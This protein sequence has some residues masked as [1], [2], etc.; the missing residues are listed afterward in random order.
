VSRSALLELL[1]ADVVTA[2]RS[3]LGWEVVTRIGGATTAARIVETEAYAGSDDPASHAF[4]GRT[5]RNA[6]MFGEPG[7]VYVYRSYGIH[8]C[9]NIV[10]GPRGLAHAVL[11]R[12][13]EPVE[14][15]E[16]MIERRGREQDL[17]N[18][19]GKLCQ[20][21]GVEG[22]HDGSSA[23]TGPVRLRPGV[24]ADQRGVAATPRIGISKAKARPWRFVLATRRP[25]PGHPG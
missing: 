22:A 17:L 16:T 20:A 6:A 15:L 13:G 19:P 7:T 21:L 25:A 1:T 8:W 11:L 3:L 12:A 5:R 10:A 23:F 24:P 4:R 9:M 18:G 2:A 14:G